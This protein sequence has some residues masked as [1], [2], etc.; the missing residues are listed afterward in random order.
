MGQCLAGLLCITHFELGAA[1]H[2]QNLPR[3]GDAHKLMWHLWHFPQGEANGVIE[4]R[5]M[6][7]AF[8]FLCQKHSLHIV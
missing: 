5:G 1:C 3:I 2:L 4:V 7:G 8:P 6:T